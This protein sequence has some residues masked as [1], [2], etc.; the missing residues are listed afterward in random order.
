MN[1]VVFAENKVTDECLE[2]GSFDSQEEAQW[3]IENNI[4]WEDENPDDWTIKIMET[5]EEYYDYYE[6]DE[7]GFDP[8]C[9]CYT[10]DC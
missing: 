3:N 4:D 6:F 9:G 10:D 8:Y 2:L 5:D 1:Y 7:C